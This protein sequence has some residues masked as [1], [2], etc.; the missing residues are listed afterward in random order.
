MTRRAGR[1]VGQTVEAAKNEFLR[2]FQRGLN[3]E[4]SIQACGRNRSTYE[5]WRRDDKEFLTAV[6]RIRS[7]EKLSGPRERQWMPFPEFSEKYLDARVFPHMGNVVDLIEG[8]EPSWV[9]PSMVFEPGEHDLV[10]S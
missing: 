4:Q 10:L 8:R 1:K 3:V 9:H 5:R 6:E 7:L 2:N